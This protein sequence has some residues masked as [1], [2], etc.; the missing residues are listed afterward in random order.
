MNNEVTEPLEMIEEDD[1]EP[2]TPEMIAEAFRQNEVDYDN[3]NVEVD[4]LKTTQL[5][6]AAEL[7]K[8]RSR[9]DILESDL[10]HTKELLENANAILI[11]LKK[12]RSGNSSL[13]SVLD[14]MLNNYTIS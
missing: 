6:L 11:I 8:Y 4:F 2:V 10:K 14:T 7:M 5:R 3:D 1:T 12:I 9:C 13:V